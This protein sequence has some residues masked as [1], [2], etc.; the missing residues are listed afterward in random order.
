MSFVLHSIALK[1]VAGISELKLK[2]IPERGVTIIRGPNETGKS[3]ILNVLDVFFDPKVKYTSASKEVKRLRPQGRDASPEVTVQFTLGPYRASMTR[4]YS[5][6]KDGKCELTIES[7]KRRQ[8]SGDEAEDWLS[9]ATSEHLDS[10]LQKALTAKQGV[11]LTALEDVGDIRPL[12]SGLGGDAADVDDASEGPLLQ[13][14][15]REFLKYF[16]AKGADNAERKG[17]RARVTELTEAR[18][19][20]QK[21][22][23]DLERVVSDSDEIR[24]RQATLV[25]TLPDLDAEIVVKEEAFEQARTAEEALT[26]LRERQEHAAAQKSSISQMVATR[27]K[28]RDRV[29]ALTDEVVLAEEAKAKAETAAK[30]FDEDSAAKREALSAA[31]A[32]LAEKRGRFEQARMLADWFAAK[33]AAAR[34]K[35]RLES[36]QQAAADAEAAREAFAKFTITQADV[37]KLLEAESLAAS[38]QEIL[39]RS[40][41][42]VQI[43][44]QVARTVGVNGDDT[45]VGQQPHTLPVAD[46]VELTID[47]V[48]VR[49]CPD[50]GARELQQ[51]AQAAAEAF[52]KLKQKLGVESVAEAAAQAREL[53]AAKEAKSRAEA[54]LKAELKGQQLSELI[55]EADAAAAQESKLAEQLADADVAAEDAAEAAEVLDVVQQEIRLAEAT[56]EA[57]AAAVADLQ[58]KSPASEVARATSQLELKSEQLAELSG[59]LER[60]EAEQSDEQL[61]QLVTDAQAQV[62]E[63]VK[64]LAE[65]QQSGLDLELAKAQLT[66]ARNRKQQAEKDAHTAELRLAELKSKVEAAEGSLQELERLQIEL[67]DA[68]FLADRA[69]AQAAAV[70]LLK[71]TLEAYQQQA[72]E[73]YEKPL[74]D[75]LEKLAAPLFGHDVQFELNENLEVIRRTVGG[76]TVDVAQLSGGAQEQLSILTRLAVAQ[77]VT[78]GEIAPVI[79]DDALGYTDELRRMRMGTALN[80]VAP[81]LQVLVL[82]CEAERYAAVEAAAEFNMDE[83]TL[84]EV[85]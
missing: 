65:A 35:Q 9:D 15:K 63:L 39:E 75:K 11:G 17:M 84:P 12:T 6:K 26:A 58:E 83:L 52:A 56:E 49:I 72:R 85:Q 66:A 5:N 20:A 27:A 70:K 30:A 22:V 53:D 41:A 82:T 69:D 62:D 74:L 28:Q 16:T 46:D 34:T 32:D 60:N 73:K 67:D 43:S 50:T 18:D 1:N 19:A 80:N 51:S 59:E 3:T 7:P 25:A 54:A 13:R 4:V 40:A 57:A 38:R 81:D 23:K 2:D 61:Q 37:T 64:Q 45:E 24:E 33:D 21:Q 44:A 55:D 47:D 77:L 36:A 48:T 79:I 68:T 76:V 42:S 71:E 78:A 10:D 14:T 8:L 31:R 29:D